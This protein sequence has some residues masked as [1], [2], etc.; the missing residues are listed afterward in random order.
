M[1]SIKKI[2]KIIHVVALNFSDTLK[3]NEALQ[4]LQDSRHL[5]GRQMTQ[6]LA[7]LL[8]NHPDEEPVLLSICGKRC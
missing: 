5:R 2:D 1:V 3:M 6:K 8:M 7:S 4:S